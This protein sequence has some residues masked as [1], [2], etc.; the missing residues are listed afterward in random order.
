MSDAAEL[1]Q[2]VTMVP[3][4]QLERQQSLLVQA[5]R[6]AFWALD[7]GGD[8]GVMMALNKNPTYTHSQ[9]EILFRI[10]RKT[11]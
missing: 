2:Q 6:E 5:L 4:Q 1:R 9:L 3:T 8:F 11:L 10:I 7:Q